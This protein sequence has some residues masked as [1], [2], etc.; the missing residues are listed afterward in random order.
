MKFVDSSYSRL[1]QWVERLGRGTSTPAPQFYADVQPVV[2]LGDMQDFAGTPPQRNFFSSASSSPV[3]ARNSSFVIASVPAN[4]QASDP[5]NAG[6][7]VRWRWN[8]FTSIKSVDVQYL[9]SPIALAA[10]AND[11]KIDL[12]TTGTDLSDTDTI[13]GSQAIARPL[14]PLEF[15]IG[16]TLNGSSASTKLRRLYPSAGSALSVGAQ[17]WWYLA[18][19]HA[20]LILNTTINELSGLE[21]DARWIYAVGEIRERA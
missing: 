10:L 2:S 6:F 19:G 8:G 21:F 12:F 16:D 15:H 5:P 1:T 7:W 13:G 3:P 17:G 11:T 14:Y 4:K 9:L 20:L 18:P